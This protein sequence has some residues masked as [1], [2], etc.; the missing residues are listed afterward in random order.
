RRSSENDE[1][2]LNWYFNFIN[3]RGISFHEFELPGR[4]ASHACVRLLE[5]DAK[6]IYAWGDQWQLSEDRKQVAAEGTPVLILGAFDFKHS[7]PWLSLDWWAK[8]LELPAD[9]LGGKG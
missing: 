6:W 4:P 5:R 7:A 1:W 8:P 2:V 9:P 3:A